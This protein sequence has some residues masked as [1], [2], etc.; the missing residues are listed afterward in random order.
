MGFSKAINF[1][2][3]FTVL[4][5]HPADERLFLEGAEN[6]TTTGRISCHQSAT[7]T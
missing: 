1:F 5:R 3:R 2:Q 4:F 7:A 6:N